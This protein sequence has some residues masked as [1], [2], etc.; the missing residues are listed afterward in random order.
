[1]LDIIKKE[2]HWIL[3]LNRPEVHNAFHPDLISQLTN[4]YQEASRHQGLKLVLLRGAGK[5]FCAGADLKWMKEMAAYSKEENQEDAEKLF[6]MF[7][8]IYSCSVPTMAYAH[9]N[10]YGGALGLLATQDI[11]VAEYNT[12]FCFSE[13]KWGLAPATIMPFV[14]TKMGVSQATHYMLSAEQF[15]T[16]DAVNMN[17]VHHCVADSEH[18]EVIKNLSKGL[19]ENGYEA[20]LATK[21]L[22]R[23][24][25]Y[26]PLEY[27]NLTSKVI[28]ERRVSEEGQAGLN[29]FLTKE[30]PQWKK[31]SQ[32]VLL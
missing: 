11:V 9:G 23:E 27:R 20:M 16:K 10:V 1:M 7:A 25:S 18:Q 30:L 2:D 28:A 29:Y 31:S 12:R 8:A 26:K 21:S 3:T 19:L 24:I 17:L 32:G 15:S 14:L 4:A 6:D 5:S 13:T 22:L